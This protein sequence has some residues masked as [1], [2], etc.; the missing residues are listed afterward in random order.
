MSDTRGHERAF[1]VGEFTCTLT[2]T[3]PAAGEPL[4]LVCEWMPHIPTS[5]TR[6]ERRQYERGRDAAIEK[7][8][9]E[10][11]AV[12]HERHLTLAPDPLEDR[13]EGVTLQ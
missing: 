6:G 5:L 13:P 4:T 1:R 3:T 7:L 12:A 11:L 8:S 9:N 10:L 2:L